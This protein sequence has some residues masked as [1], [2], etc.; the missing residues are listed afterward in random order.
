MR[1]YCR[2]LHTPLCRLVIVGGHRSGSRSRFFVCVFFSLFGIALRPFGNGSPIILIRW[3]FSDIEGSI[4]QPEAS[5]ALPLFS[6]R[7][8]MCWI[9]VLYSYIVSIFEIL[10]CKFNFD[11]GLKRIFSAEITNCDGEKS[12]RH[13]TFLCEIFENSH[14]PTVR[15]SW[16]SFAPHSL[17]VLVHN[18]LF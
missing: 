7:I 13:V 17:H 2:H 6:L 8:R 3:E 14:F 12:P 15:I 9:G 11:F 18:R 16:E 10:L 1:I 5:E 4:A